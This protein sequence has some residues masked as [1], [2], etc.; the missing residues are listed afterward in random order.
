MTNKEKKKNLIS[1]AIQVA[2]AGEGDLQQLQEVNEAVAATS[3]LNDHI[4][5]GGIKMR[6]FRLSTVA[7]LK[8]INSPYFWCAC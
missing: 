3:L 1:K 4:E 2:K 5:I 6:T 7:M 8:Q